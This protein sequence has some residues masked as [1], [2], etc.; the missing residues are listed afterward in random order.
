VAYKDLKAIVEGFT[1][2]DESIF[3]SSMGFGQM[4]S[5]NTSVPTIFRILIVDTD[6]I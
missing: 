2:K 6:Y 3:Y 5:S 4:N 1:T